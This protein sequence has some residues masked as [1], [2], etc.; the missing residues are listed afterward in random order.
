MF[1]NLQHTEYFLSIYY[2][3]VFTDVVRYVAVFLYQTYL[4]IISQENAGDKKKRFCHLFAIEFLC[5]HLY[6]IRFGHDFLRNP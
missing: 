5:F 1:S 6:F 4:A 2:F 3:T